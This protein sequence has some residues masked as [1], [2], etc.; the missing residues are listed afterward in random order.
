M[1]DETVTWWFNRLGNFTGVIDALNARHSNDPVY[2]E[3]A[4]AIRAVV[5]AML[6]HGRANDETCEIPAVKETS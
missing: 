1:N 4:E 3:G 2:T 6:A 5:N